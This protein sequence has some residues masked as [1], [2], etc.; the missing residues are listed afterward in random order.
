MSWVLTQ[1]SYI[2]EAFFHTK[3]TL[4]WDLQQQR[5]GL[6]YLGHRVVCVKMQTA[7]EKRRARL[8]MEGWLYYE[9]AGKK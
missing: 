7:L 8:A 4:L 2:Q 6:E 3:I 9:A 5:L 1:K